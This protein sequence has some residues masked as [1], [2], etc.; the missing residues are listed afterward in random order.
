MI[1]PPDLPTTPDKDLVAWALEGREDGRRGL[2]ERYGPAVYHCALKIVRD[3]D[4]AK[5]IMQETFITAFR[6]LDGHDPKRKFSA[7]ILRIATNKAIDHRRRKRLDTVSLP[8]NTP[9]PGIQDAFRAPVAR[10]AQRQE[11]KLNERARVLEDAI[12]QLPV[13]QARCIRLRFY[14]NQT[15]K[16]I[17]RRL[18]IPVGTV[19]THIHRGLNNLQETLD[20][21]DLWWLHSD[22]SGPFYTPPVSDQDGPGSPPQGLPGRGKKDLP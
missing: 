12:D 6:A 20:P 17:A 11:E 21:G 13:K 7:W 5:D 22:S 2:M 19:K 18:R 14:E 3:P 1:P 16:Q 15:P 4:I 8:L 10:R 9:P